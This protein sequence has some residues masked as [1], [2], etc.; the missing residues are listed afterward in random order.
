MLN[1]QTTLYI[2]K[3]SSFSTLLHLHHPYPRSCCS[4][5]VTSSSSSSASS[6]S[7]H[8]AIPSNP[9]CSAKGRLM[10]TLNILNI[11]EIW[12]LSHLKST[13]GLWFKLKYS[14]PFYIVHFYFQNVS[15]VYT[16]GF[17]SAFTVYALLGALAVLLFLLRT[18]IFLF[19][20][21]HSGNVYPL[22]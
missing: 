20:C 12:V 19:V 17:G 6:R 11:S 7:V 9:H 1:N 14:A 22:I 8:W 21:N 2:T 18:H 10:L 16:E 4:A 13:P 3:N 15:T 5:S